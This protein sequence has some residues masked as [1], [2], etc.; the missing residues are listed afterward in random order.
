MS[1]T[2]TMD[3]KLAEFNDAYA[4]APVYEDYSPPPSEYIVEVTQAI[5][6]IKKQQDGTELPW[7]KL[8]AKIHDPND[9]AV[10]GKNF[11]LGFWSSKT[12]GMMKGALQMIA[13]K[14][15][16]DSIVEAAEVF[17]NSVGTF[18]RVNV[19]E[20]PGKEGRV[21]T[22]V[23]ILAVLDTETPVDPA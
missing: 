18:L 1:D 22:N 15:L 12:F 13:G 3:A 17:D 7:F 11:S 21:Y 20:K 6:D 4:K 8:I 9:P 14:E 19:T 10:D 23:K 2:S 5:R 16:S